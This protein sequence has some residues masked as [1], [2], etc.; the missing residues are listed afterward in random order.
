MTTQP[1][2]LVLAGPNGAGKSMAAARLLPTSIPF[3]NADEVAKT[4]PNYPSQGADIEA[5]RIV[6]R[7]M[8]ELER[9]HASFAVE[10]TLASRSL[11]AR[12]RRLRQSGYRF[13]LLYLWTPN[14]EFSVL[15]V[16]ARVRAG[17]HNIP[18]ETIRRRYAAGIR[19]FFAIYQPLADKWEVYNN[20]ELTPTLVAEGIM[21][22]VLR[23]GDRQI[24]DRMREGDS[25]E[26]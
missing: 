19:N 3:I 1:Q 4:L 22:H 5:G 24:W 21:S 13:R 9:E 6:L 16:A 14:D 7:R 23:V 2:I 11:A 10:T 26:P 12:I 8:D 18:E 25:D 15:R 17:G 20:T